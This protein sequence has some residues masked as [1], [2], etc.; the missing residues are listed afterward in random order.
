M[1]FQ[2]NQNEFHSKEVSQFD[3]ITGV[4]TSPTQT[5][6][7]IKN[8]EKKN[9][10]VIPFI[11]VVILG[12]LTIYLFNN[13]NELTSESKSMQKEY[14]Q[15]MIYS[16]EKQEKENV[17]SSEQAMKIKEDLQ[18][19][20]DSATG[21]TGFLG[22]QI[23]NILYILFLSLVAFILVKIL[24]GKITYLNIINIIVLSMLILA[25]GDLIN[26][27]I[28]ILLGTNT[29]LGLNILLKPPSV[30]LYISVF[31]GAIDLFDVWFI[32][33]LSIGLSKVASIKISPVII[34]LLILRIIIA[35]ILAFSVLLPEIIFG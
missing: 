18:K 32:V 15:K 29:N 35:V 16:I 5:F 19:N 12:I 6:D 31:F 4:F 34:T 8:T 21:E 28:S 10:W 7:A 30:P 24:K 23:S 13:D 11:I 25:I 3:I 27:V 33:I 2:N 14:M 26:I 20:I 1:E 22:L 9:L 17:I